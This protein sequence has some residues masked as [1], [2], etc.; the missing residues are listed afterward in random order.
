M[1]TCRFTATLFVLVVVSMVA[2]GPVTVGLAARQ[3]VTLKNA[4]VVGAGA[5]FPAPLYQRWIEEFVKQSPGFTIYYD[6]VGSGAGTQRFMAQAV[7]FG[8]SDSGHER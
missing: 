3:T 1:K 6:A 4:D 8:A 2:V 7:D 5:T